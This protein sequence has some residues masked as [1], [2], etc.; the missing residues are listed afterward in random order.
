[1]ANT[2]IGLLGYSIEEQIY[3]GSR[4]VVYRGTRKSDR[5]PVVIKLLRNEFPRFNELI[6]FRNQYIIGKNLDFSGIIKT[7][8]L[9]SYYNSYALILEDF[10]GISLCSYLTS[11]AEASKQNGETSSLP[12]PLFLSIA[13]QV[14]HTLEGLCQHRVIHKDLKP[15][16][17]VINP[18]SKEV[19]LIDFSIA[20]LL[21]R[22]TQEIQ[23][24]N[25]LE[26]TLPYISP[27]QTGRMNR[28]IDYRTDFYSLGVTFYEM[29][30]GQLP[31]QTD[32]PMD[33]VH[34]HL[35]Q[36]PIPVHHLNKSVPSVLSF[37]VSK[38]MAKNAEDRYQSAL[39]LKYDLENC[40]HQWKET[41]EIADFELGS[42]D[43][44]DRFIIPEKLYGREVEVQA[45]L[46][47]FERVSTGSAEMMLVTGFSGIGKTAV[48]NE[49]HKPIVRQ[50]GYFIKGKFDQFQRNLPFSAFVQAFRDLMGQLLSETDAK[51]EQWKTQILAALGENAQVVVDVIPELERIIGE[52][53]PASELTGNA[54]Q[55]RFNRLFENF[56]SVFTTQEHPLVIFLDDLQWA[57]S[58]S[59]N[60]IQL[61]TSDR[62]RRYLFLMGAYRDNEVSPVHPLILALSDIQKTGATVNTITLEPLELSDLNCLIADT[63]ACSTA[64]ALPLTELVYQKP[65]GN[66]FFSTQFLK[67][68]YKDGLITFNYNA[69]YWQC[70]IATVRILALTD[71]VVEFMALQLRKLPAPTQELLK[72]AACI[73]NQFDLATLGIVNGKTPIETANILWKTLQEGLILPVSEVYKFYQGEGNGALT[74][75]QKNSDP[76][77]TYKFLHDRVQQAAYS[78]IPDDRKQAT[79]LKIGQL[80]QHNSSEIEKEEKLFDIVG[81]LNLGIELITQPSEREALA[82]L[83]LAAGRKARSSTAY[84]AARVYVQAGIELLTA[85]CWQSQYELTLNLYVGGAEAAYLNGDFDGMEQIAALV[86]QNAQ[87]ILDKI[88]IYEISIVAQTAQGKILEAI[89]VGR[90]ALGQLGV[91]L[92]TAPDEALIGKALQALATQLQGRRIEQLANLPVMTDAE[93]KA[94]MQVMAMLFSAIFIGMPGLLPLLSSAMV[95]LSLQCGNTS[96]STVGYVIHGMV[97]CAF[98]GDAETGYG[99]GKLAISLLDRFNVREFKSVIA[100]LFGSFIQHHQEPVRATIPILKAGYTSGM[101]TGDFLSA[102]FSILDYFYANFFSGIELKTWEP[103]IAGYS[104]ALAQ[105]KQ[106][107][108]LAYLDMKQQTVR[109][110]TE[111][112]SQPDCLIGDAYDETVMIPKHHQDNELS[113]IALVYIYK[114]LL[115][116][117]WGNYPAALNHIS[118]AKPYLMALS[119][120]IHIPIFHF[121][122]ALTHLA[123]FPTQPEI[124][125]ADILTQ[126]EIHQSTLQ[127]WAQNAP[128]NHLHKW[129]LVEAEKHRVLG[130]KAD[131]IEHYD[132]AIS[133]AK[134]NQFLNEEALA[135][136]LAAKFY[137][138]WGKEKFAKIYAIEAYYAY[139]RWGAKAKVID[140]EERYPQL[141]APILQQNK[142]RSFEA[143]TTSNGTSSSTKNQTIA[144]STSSTVIDLPAVIKAS[145][146]LSSEIQLD[147]LLS[148]LMQVVVKNAGAQTGVLILNEEG[149]WKIAVHCSA[150][151][152]CILQNV[153]IGQSQEIPPTIINYVKRTKETLVF[154][155]ATTQLTFAS[156]PYMKQQQPK[157]ILCTPILHQ[158]KM[159]AILYLE[160]NLT[161]GAFTGYQVGILNIL[162]S[163]AAISLQNARLYQQ[164]QEYAQKLELYLNDLKQMQL[165][166]VQNE[167]MSALGNL[168]AGVAHEINNPVGFIAGNLQPAQYYVQ[169]LF[170]L[171]DLYQEKFPVPGVEIEAEIED[172]DLEYLREDLPKLIGS[173]K[174]GV[175]RIRS[176][177][178]SLR[179]FSRADSDR[180]VPF[181]IHDGLDSTIL[182]LKHRL[183]A[184][185]TRPAIEIVKEYG[186][187]PPVECFP[188]Q[189]NQVFMNIL[190]NAIDVL[191]EQSKGRSF[192]EI[193]SLPNQI[194][195][196]TAVSEKGER[197]LIKIK[198]NGGG[199]SDEVKQ[200]IFDH[201]F[202]TK[203]VGQGTGLGL[204]I[205]RKIVEEKH[206]GTLEVN[207][208]LGYGSEF[209]ISIPING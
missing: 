12:I 40:L 182:I 130:N 28:G 42:R 70:D 4:T 123:L 13:V 79:H 184:N 141:L 38:L 91:E 186:N 94:A 175:D 197:A 96:A 131:A 105:A 144:G 53:P 16:N 27:E 173:M 10:G 51:V 17:I 87:T 158:G 109:N 30:T 153:L 204:S 58:A 150:R 149:N 39:G 129:Y 164:S 74:I 60:L 122:A 168:V 47:A 69:Q 209:V 68:L 82:Q 151:Q 112:V 107:T 62:E 113:A 83:N 7:Y 59:L 54:A 135:N 179:T 41:G 124:E 142:T 137:L 65:K 167:K 106:Y 170:N 133:G 115:A 90:N 89:A 134:E 187:L 191:E 85:N 181:N 110:L 23:N 81:H 152:D 71:D 118:Q 61:L 57:D 102:G 180:P 34:C 104:A 29:L 75:G 35:A 117:S 146:A 19:K 199:I 92:P 33:L 67:S 84:A 138:E 116:Y 192:S 26:G 121:Y 140:L 73:G 145:Q 46:A 3:A 44:C 169:D 127:Q 154:D 136:E 14:A 78:L 193:Q 8:N 2:T 100:N 52:Q 55:N 196:Q 188:G 64:L 31:F 120:L 200:K 207:S 178:T 198:D 32:D 45:L 163:Q 25:V 139:S 165:Q 5:Q 157:S 174:E 171:I 63:L 80:L 155:D 177:S 147:Q 159:M 160:N 99:F 202:T 126:V 176:I 101:E 143:M 203:P 86:L 1:M 21:P 189:L 128:M 125:Q 190:A 56:I 43:L 97:L 15:A 132:C 172:I 108:A 37:I 194:A 156:D 36:Q 208:S 20:S 201:L 76:L 77:P 48:V 103:E 148:T 185:E 9:E 24:P 50:R 206:Q 166:L 205:A 111:A 66:P 95:S 6:H 22:E 183:K 49:V 161:T 11:V 162:C 18:T 98:F 195:I 114:L 88:K 72:L 93:A 119:G